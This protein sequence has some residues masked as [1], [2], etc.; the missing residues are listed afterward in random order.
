MAG[1]QRLRQD[2]GSGMDPL[3]TPPH[4]VEAEQAVLGGLLLD[5][6]AWD[7][8][9]DCVGAEDF[10]RPDHRLIFEAIAELVA[11][12]RLC[13][14]VTVSEQLDRLGKLQR[15]RRPGLPGH[16][17]ARHAHCRQRARL[18]ADRARARAAARAGQRR[19]RHRLLGVQR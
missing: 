2:A 7:Q 13:D 3:R 17:G 11:Q 10:Y 1:P 16:A 19:Q 12:S 14:V 4:S 8:V 9:G 5:T 18:C 6:A 15:R